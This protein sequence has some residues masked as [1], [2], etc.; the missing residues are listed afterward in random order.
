MLKRG[1]QTPTQSRRETPRR[2]LLGPAVTQTH[3]DA[4]DPETHRS[5]RPTN[6]RK[7]THRPR[8]TA[9]HALQTPP[10]PD[11]GVGTGGR[12]ENKSRMV[13][14]FVEHIS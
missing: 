13:T 12:V 1:S 7:P 3:T 2:V 6:A 9:P 4:L 11:S 5:T 10:R 8:H 14:D